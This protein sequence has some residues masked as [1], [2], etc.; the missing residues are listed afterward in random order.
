MMW[1]RASFLVLFG[2]LAVCQGCRLPIAASGPMPIVVTTESLTLAWDPP[3]PDLPAPL[4]VVSYHVYYRSHGSFLWT[5][6]AE[7]GGPRCT[8]QHAD[9]GDGS[10]DFAVS[11][12]DGLGHQSGL[13]SSMGGDA[14]PVGGWYV[15]WHV[16]R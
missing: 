9:V 15:L 14:E 7:V 10:F 13:H 6:I 3:Q 2:A 5:P 1:A 8:L 16:G 12:V 4:G 11:S